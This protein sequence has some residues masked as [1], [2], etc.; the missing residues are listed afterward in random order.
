LLRFGAVLHNLYH[1]PASQRG[2]AGS[3]QKGRYES[4]LFQADLGS[5]RKKE[6]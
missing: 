1:A 4:P 2:V 3:I 5:H 6:D